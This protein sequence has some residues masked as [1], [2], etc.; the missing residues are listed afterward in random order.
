M[1]EDVSMYHK[2]D[3]CSCMW[4]SEQDRGRGWWWSL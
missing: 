3:E 2:I 1:S 4:S